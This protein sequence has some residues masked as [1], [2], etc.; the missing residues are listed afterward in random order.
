ML[1]PNDTQ[2]YN[3]Q[4]IYFSEYS[5]LFIVIRIFI[6]MQKSFYIKKNFIIIKHLR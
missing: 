2:I 3:T 1:L 6:I 4:S 5:L